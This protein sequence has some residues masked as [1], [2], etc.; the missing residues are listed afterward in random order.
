[1]GDEW[2]ERA[3][4]RNYPTAIFFPAEFDDDQTSGDEDIAKQICDTCPVQVECR[5]AQMDEAYGIRGRLSPAERGFRSRGRYDFESVAGLQGYVLEAM[6][7]HRGRWMNHVDVNNH[8]LAEYGRKWPAN[9]VG[10]ALLR[11]HRAGDLDKDDSV[12]P[13]RYRMPEEAQ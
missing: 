5:D 3:A 13:P 12:R 4:C 10:S 8:L 2:M 6:R 1:M 9:S 7:L 11:Y